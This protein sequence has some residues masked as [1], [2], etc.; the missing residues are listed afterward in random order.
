L[1]EVTKEAGWLRR[2][3]IVGI[4]RGERGCHTRFGAAIEDF[5]GGGFE[6]GRV[7]GRVEGK[8]GTVHVAPPLIG[9]SVAKIG[10]LVGGG[11]IAAVEALA[12]LP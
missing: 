11:E 2:I 8:A 12:R 4:E 7:D 9:E 5:G 6:R 3:G 10:S 1:R